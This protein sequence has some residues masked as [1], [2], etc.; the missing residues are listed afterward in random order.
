MTLAQSH[1]V[2]QL[3][4][5]PITIGTLNP[6]D[7]AQQW[8]TNLETQLGKLPVPQLKL[9]ELFHKDSWWRDMLALDWD[10]HT[11]HTVSEIEQYIGRNQSRARLTAFRLQQMGRFQPK[12]ETPVEGLRWISSI[13]FFESRVGRGTGV[14]RLTQDGAGV[15]KAYSL[16]TSL[17]GLK[18]FEEPLGL[19]RPEGT[20]ESMP[21]NPSKENW[22]ERRQRQL[23]F[24]NEEPTVLLVGAG[25]AGLNTAARLQS[26]GISCLLVDRNERIGDNWRKRYRTL[27]THDPVEFTHMAYLPF[28]R[29]WPQFTPKDK[30]ADWF[31]A[32]ASIMELNVWLKTR[33]KSAAYDDAKAQ[34]S[35]TV[36]RGDTGSERVLHPRHIV[37]CTGHSGEPKI[38]TFPG[39]AQFKG[40]VYH[41]S[42]HHDASDYDVKGK[43]VVVVGTGNSGHDIAQNFYE[44]GA[45]VTMLQR[46]GTYVIT[47]A[48]GV[49][50]QHEGLHEENGPSTEE[51]DIISESLPYPV[52]F[53][54]DVHFTK[55]AYKAEKDILDGLTAAGFELDVGVDGA[56][57]SRAYMTRGGGYYI[58]VGCSQLIADRK[59]KIKR[60]P[61]GIAGFNDRELLLKDGSALDADIVVLAT[62]YD[63]MRTTV[64]KVLGDRVADRCRDVWD[65]DEE[66]EINAMWRPSGHPGF[67][68][69]GGNLALCR[70]YSKFLALQIKAI[71][72]GLVSQDTDTVLAK[73]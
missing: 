26:L 31:E 6:R 21:G 65:L 44:N 16:Y 7:I 48:K 13:F 73:L 12:I 50:M 4:I 66:G 8:L 33:V 69:M 70:V 57:I 52:K 20:I 19:Q 71:E 27:V 41:G 64:R 49:L 43:K 18:G 54:L 59:I 17:Q 55:R 67:W 15:W 3:P 39:Q 32:Y 56:G 72:A 22:L 62:G 36:V 42:Q 10:F 53:A 63:N 51:A 25:Q 61:E 68:F 28:P 23:E 35:V 34:W 37:W 60:S 14:L 47:A 40:T 9:S 5:T 46:S 11:I 38:P 24:Q 1:Y 29:N 58:D 30:L 2:I 45:D